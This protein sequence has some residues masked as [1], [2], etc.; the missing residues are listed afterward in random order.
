MDV[1]WQQRLSSY[2]KAL[3][4]LNA[5]VSFLKGFFDQLDFEED[6]IRVAEEIE[7]VVEEEE[8]ED[9]YKQG[10]IKSFEF[11]YELAWNVMKDF[12]EYQGSS[13]IKGSRD[14]IRYAAQEKLIADGHLWMQMIENR[15]R[16]AH[17]YDEETANEIFAQIISAYHRAFID[18]EKQMTQIK[19]AADD[20][21]SR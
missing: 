5:N 19:D 2:R 16:T 12:A 8:I 20:Q 10:L 3:E 7:R 4:K 17:T 21:G 6:P 13:D 1:R 15:Q 11:T 14:A 9:M 18:F